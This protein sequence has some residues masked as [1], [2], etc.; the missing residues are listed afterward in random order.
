MLF[1]NK[2]L[3]LNNFFLI[4]LICTSFVSF[5]V[6]FQYLVGFDL[7]GY[8]S[9]DDPPRNPGPFGDEW[10]SGSYLLKFS[11]FSFFYIIEIYKNMKFKNTLLISIITLHL[12]GLLLS[13]NRMPFILF[14]FACVLIVLFVKNLRTIMSLGLIIFV[15][16]FSLIMTYDSKLKNYY[17]NVFGATLSK[18][19]FSEVLKT[20]KINEE[21]DGVVDT[22]DIGTTFLRTSGHG[23]IFHTA[24]KLW[25]EQPL[26]GHGLK[27]FR[28]KCW[29]ILSKEEEK[30]LL[31]E[32]M[33]FGGATNLACSTH[34][35]NYYLEML[36]EVGM[37]GVGLI[38]VFF[39]ILLK[40]SYYILK[41]YN[42][43]INPDVA[44]LMPFV[45]IMFL[46]IWPIKS[47]GSFFTTGN[48]TFFWLVVAILI[49]AKL[50]I[51]KY[52]S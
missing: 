23:A 35:H 19:N 16:I 36:V 26:F 27:S 15:G 24:I 44:L 1:T 40:D 21:E 38:I 10:I 42:Q 39:I 8:K 41:K 47:S 50:Q 20:K 33:S 37:I 46:E 28:V 9:F 18:I 17:H 32:G 45:I 22:N 52:H 43:K 34:P 25:K 5:D 2:I 4:S 3:K 13:G 29:E 11:F 12:T 49:S 6:I 30:E 51:K 31:G 14:L 7:F 48:A